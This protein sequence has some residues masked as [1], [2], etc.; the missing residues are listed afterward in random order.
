[1]AQTRKFENALPAS[2][3]APPASEAKVLWKLVQKG[4]FDE[5]T[6]RGLI[7][8][9]IIEA[10][11][12]KRVFGLDVAR[13][14]LAYR[15]KVLEHFDALAAGEATKDGKCCLPRTVRRKTEGLLASSRERDE[16]KVAFRC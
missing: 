7:R 15:G 11:E 16:N 2:G 6:I 14:A 12:I 10:L 8:I 1:L 13:R 9:T 5:A 4:R 3:L